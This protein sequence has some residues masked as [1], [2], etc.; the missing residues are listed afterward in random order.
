MATDRRTDQHAA[1]V[2]QRMSQMG[3]AV[4][5]VPDGCNCSILLAGRRLLKAEMTVLH[6]SSLTNKQQS[7]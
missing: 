7:R 2:F 4:V 1:G 6:T 3:L 5:I